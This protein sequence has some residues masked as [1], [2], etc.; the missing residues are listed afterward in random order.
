MFSALKQNGTP[1]YRLAREGVEVERKS[2]KVR[3]DTFEILE[4][5]LPD[6]DV[7]VGCSKGTYIRTLCHDLG[8]K[9]GCGAHLT[10]LRRISSGCFSV[11]ASYT[12]EQLQERHDRQVP[13]PLI[14]PADALEK[15]P[16]LQVKGERLE[17]LFNGLPPRL[18]DLPG[19]PEL[20]PGTAVRL[21]SGGE[22]V[23]IAAYEPH[24][25][26]KGPKDFKNLKVFPR[27]SDDG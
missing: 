4:C 6:V 7:R 10:A 23:A 20:V 9:L 17:R 14:S 13:M 15:W 27:V 16:G 26:D 8:E 19:H 24:E 22:L 21:L 25:N 5:E 3:I 12:V 11:S 1:L 18:E 2:R